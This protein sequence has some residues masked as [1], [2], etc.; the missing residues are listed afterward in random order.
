MSGKQPEGMNVTDLKDSKIMVASTIRM[1][2]ADEVMYHV[3]NEESPTTIWLML[4]SRYMS[5]SLIN[6]LLPKKKIY[7]LKVAE[8]ST[9]DQHINVF[10]QIIS[11]LNQ[12]DVKFEEEDMALIILNS[13]PKSYDNLV[14]TLMWG[15]ETLELEEITGAL[16]SFNQRKKADDGSS[17]G[18]GLVAKCNQERGRNKSQSDSRK[19]KS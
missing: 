6:K 8:G 15:K 4:K 14:T 10:N 2:L 5:K 13:L 12:V 16:L 1:C 11:D 19:N 3:M 9:L 17:Q 7:G 18:E